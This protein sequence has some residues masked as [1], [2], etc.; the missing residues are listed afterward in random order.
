[1]K[2]LSLCDQASTPSAPSEA[3]PQ[4]DLEAD[5]DTP[6]RRLDALRPAEQHLGGLASDGV[7]ID[8]YAGQG[9]QGESPELAAA[10][11]DDSDILRHGKAASQ[12]F[13]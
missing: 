4:D 1:M 12:G 13:A 11:T 9:R 10:E 6:P 7:T 8:P 5:I 2:A 3:L